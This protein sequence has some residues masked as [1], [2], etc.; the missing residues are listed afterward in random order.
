MNR[1]NVLVGLGTIVAGG[2]AALGTGAFST[3]TADR[4]IEVSTTDDANAYLKIT[5]GD[6]AGDYVTDDDGEI[7]ID[8]GYDSETEG[9]NENA[10]TRFD[11]LIKIS[12]NRRDNSDDIHVSITSDNDDVFSAYE[13]EYNEGDGDIDD[14]EL[15]D[16]GLDVGFE[17][18]LKDK[19]DFDDEEITIT[20]DASTEE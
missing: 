15:D 1:R 6:G 16:E 17:F 14:K 12:K 5:K 3:V 10:L 18:D 4:T 2:G 20:I 19:D 7:E 9:L 8:F 11:N 13:G